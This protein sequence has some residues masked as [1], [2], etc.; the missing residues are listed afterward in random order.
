LGPVQSRAAGSV[1][2]L[3]RMLV[4]PASLPSGPSESGGP[5]ARPAQGATGYV[6]DLR[7]LDKAASRLGARARHQPAGPGHIAGPA[8]VTRAP[9]RRARSRKSR[10]VDLATCPPCKFRQALRPLPQSVCSATARCGSRGRIQDDGG[11]ALARG[12]R[13]SSTPPSPRV[14]V[15]R[16]APCPPVPAAR[17]AQSGPAQAVQVGPSVSAVADTLGWREAPGVE[18]ARPP[19][20][21][22]LPFFLIRHA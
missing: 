18:L 22:D 21:Q 1:S 12:P 15:L 2:T 7:P 13:G 10:V 8:R 20:P 19:R 3:F 17:V 11:G 14:C 6:T 5:R 9:T 16:P 4:P